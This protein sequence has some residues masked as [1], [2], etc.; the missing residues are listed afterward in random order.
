MSDVFSPDRL[1]KDPEDPLPG[2]INEPEPADEVDGE[3]EWEVDKILASK[4]TKG[5][6]TYKVQ[7][8][9]GDEDP[10]WYDAGAFRN[11]PIKLK[12]YHEENPTKPGPPKRLREWIT[13]AEEDR[14]EEDHEEDNMPLQDTKTTKLRRTRAR[15]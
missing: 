7:W 1:P 4:V 6:L 14:F 15:H 10:T 11:S 8:L 2:Q 5:V 13:A 3:P 12:Q 9:G